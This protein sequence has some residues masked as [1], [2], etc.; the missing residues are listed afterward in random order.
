MSNKI[1][2][3][4]PIR[5]SIQYSCS[6]QTN[7]PTFLCLIDNYPEP[8]RWDK[9]RGK[10]FT[11]ALTPFYPKIV[12]ERIHYADLV[13]RGKIDSAPWQT[14]WSADGLILS[15]SSY[16]LSEN[17]VREEFE[18]LADF[19]RQYPKPILGICFGHQLLAHTYGFPVRPMSQEYID[20]EWWEH[21]REPV[22]LPIRK[23]FPLLEEESI[24]VEF[25]H[26]EEIEETE[27]FSQVFEVFA[28]TEACRIQV[29]MHREKPFFGVQFHPETG[30]D[31]R[32]RKDGQKIF[33]GFVHRVLS[34]GI[35]INSF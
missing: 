16:N 19:I 22:F 14:V 17:K 30:K 33:E 8:M 26:H 2:S 32:A 27:E 10:E 6:M 11:E 34:V 1:G 12:W 9:G 21:T 28:S 25:S 13:D 35:R 7:Q 29:M 5:G 24:W 31:P 18:P 20:S 3:H 15:G 23:G 4:L